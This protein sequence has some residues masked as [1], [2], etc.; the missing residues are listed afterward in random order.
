MRILLLKVIEK[1]CAD[2]KLIWPVMDV[3]LLLTLALEKSNPRDVER[4][5]SLFIRPCLISCLI[6]SL[7]MMVLKLLSGHR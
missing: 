3:D 6:L 2:T 5:M 1:L 7:A 4:F